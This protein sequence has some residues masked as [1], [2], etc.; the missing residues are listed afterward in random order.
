M[1]ESISFYRRTSQGQ[2]PVLHQA[3][4]SKEEVREEARG[5]VRLAHASTMQTMSSTRKVRA[6]LGREEAVLGCQ[7]Q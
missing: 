3:S 7:D 4:D 6:P 2:M 5:Q 1:Q